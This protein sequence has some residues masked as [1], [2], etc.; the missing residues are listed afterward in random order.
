MT[1]LKV[2][3]VVPRESADSVSESLQQVGA[4]ATSLFNA[5][6]EEIVDASQGT[7][8]IWSQVRV[9]ALLKV[10]MSL[11]SLHR[12]L[13]EHGAEDVRVSFIPDV[14]WE[15][16]WQKHT[17]PKQF[18]RLRVLPRESS[19]EVGGPLVRLD[20]GLAFGTGDHATTAMC[21]S[22]LESIDLD[23]SKVLDFGCGSG[24][25]GLA[26]AKLG[27]SQVTAIDHDEKA[28]E[29]TR[30]NAIFNG[31]NL[32]LGKTIPVNQKFDVVVANILLNTLV[33]Y[34]IDLTSTVAQGG[35]IGLTGLLAA[36]Q[37]SIVESFP[38]V[39]FDSPVQ[40]NEWILMIGRKFSDDI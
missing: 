12:L 4:I 38:H 23:G 10:G 35:V 17:I 37:E 13:G 28:I 39:C 32:T 30:Q 11:Q 36:Q 15:S 29:V 9:E 5:G 16:A 1:W 20:P 8:T 6:S 7:A 27:A 33:Q 21:L 14:E 18:G 26:A 25:L 40:E 3:F 19:A 24:I 34:A 31:V 22:W 2:A